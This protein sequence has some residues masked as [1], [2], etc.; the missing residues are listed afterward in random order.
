MGPALEGEG[1]APPAWTCTE[2]G[3]GRHQ[4]ATAAR[5]GLLFAIP[6]GTAPRWRGSLSSTDAKTADCRATTTPVKDS[7]MAPLWVSWSY[8]CPSPHPTSQ[9]QRKSPGTVYTGRKFWH[10]ELLESCSFWCQGTGRWQVRR[11]GEPG[12]CSGWG[13]NFTP[14]DSAHQLSDMDSWHIPLDVTVPPLQKRVR[15]P[16]SRTWKSAVRFYLGKCLVET[17][18]VSSSYCN[19]VGSFYASTMSYVRSGNRAVGVL[20]LEKN[21]GTRQEVHGEASCSFPVCRAMT[22]GNDK[23]GDSWY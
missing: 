14:H 6:E 19:P 23:I 15:L 1:G 11:T 9:G 21:P 18:V 7:G 4:A 17:L 20:M 2:Q 5:W 22:M 13:L 8:P 3:K 12:L 16:T 10:K